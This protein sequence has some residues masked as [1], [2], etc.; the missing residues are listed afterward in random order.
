MFLCVCCFSDVP[1]SMNR[2]ELQALM[3]LDDIIQN[4]KHRIDILDC[5]AKDGGIGLQQIMTW[6]QQN[7]KPSSLL[8]S[9]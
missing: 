2:T 3:R 5:S 4:C 1:D 8:S 6:I 9:N 7:V